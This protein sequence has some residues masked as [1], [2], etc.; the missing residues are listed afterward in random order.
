MLLWP[1]TF[2]DLIDVILIVV[3]PV[4]IVQIHWPSRRDPILCDDDGWVAVLLLDEVEDLAESKWGNLQPGRARVQP[5]AISNR[6]SAP[7]TH[8][9]MTDYLI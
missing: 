8:S 5:G 2:E 9:K 6:S 7:N 4:D 1:I 3:N